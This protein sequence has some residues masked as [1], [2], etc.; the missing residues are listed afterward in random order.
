MPVDR[1]VH[2]GQVFDGEQLG[3][4][5]AAVALDGHTIAEVGAAHEVLQRWPGIPVDHYPGATL[6]P[7]LID[8]H[9]HL[10]MPGDGT[11]YEP[12]VNRA[13]EARFAQAAANL[14]AHAAGGVTTV[15]DLGSHPDFLSWLP[16][17]P[18]DLPRLIRYGMPVTGVGGHMHLFGGDA[19]DAEQAAAIAR[20][21][22]ALGAEGIKIAATGG[23]TE[24]TIPHHETLTE[25]QIRAAVSV[26]HE[27]GLLAT[28]H[29]LSNESIRRAIVS[30]SDGIE[31]IAFLGPDG[32][33]AFDEKLVAL[34]VEHG[35]T[36]GSTL[37]CNFHYV[38][39]AEQGEVSDHEVDEQR[40]R[41]DYYVHNAGRLRAL[42]GRI[43]P[44]SDAGWKHTAFGDFST[45]LGLLS[46]SGYSATEILTLATSGNATYLRIDHEVG[47]IRPGHRADLALF[48]GDPTEDIRATRNVL[49]TYRDGRRIA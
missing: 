38:E 46:L 8:S 15:R 6:S 27:H 33:A 49:A 48:D 3:A 18:A 30:G 41:T 23:G 14:R 37:G 31:H 47:Y 19:A 35:T 2:A 36:F 24:G 4:G 20:R 44:A 12:A 43:A 7:G 39:L 17:E 42:G 21:N 32:S 1:L 16:A 40:E 9:V 45:E 22:I 10:T 28:T 29:A 13:A 34:A 5:E 26:A 25:D 11:A